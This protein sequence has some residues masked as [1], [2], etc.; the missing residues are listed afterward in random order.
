MTHTSHLQRHRLGDWGRVLAGSFAAL[1]LSSCAAPQGDGAR[2]GDTAASVPDNSSADRRQASLQSVALDTSWLLAPD[3]ARD[4][5][6]ATDT[7]A[8]LAARYGAANVMRDRIDEGEGML[9]PGTVVFPDD[10]R[11]RLEI[12]WGDTVAYR[13]PLYVTAVGSGWVLYPGIGFGTSLREL[14]RMNGAPFELSGFAGHSP[15]TITDWRGGSLGRAFADGTAGARVTLQ[16]QPEPPYPAGAS[17]DPYTSENLYPSGDPGIQLLNP[18]V[19]AMVVR[20]R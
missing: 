10:P 7:E 18:R 15:G 11:R 2:P 17:T 14:E 4:A 1:L 19:V 8:T 9:V 5:V 12:Q 20:P 16:L 6:H 3:P 13:A